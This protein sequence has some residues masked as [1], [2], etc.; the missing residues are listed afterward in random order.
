MS[1]EEALA[2]IAADERVGDGKA[3][4]DAELTGPLRDASFVAECG[5]PDSMKVTLAVV[6]RRGRA[7]G[8]SVRTTPPDDA[9][10]RCVDAHARALRWPSSPYADSFTTTY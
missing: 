4:S 2:R 6:V 3:L 9:V 1:Y 8:V 5:A 7:I 10:V